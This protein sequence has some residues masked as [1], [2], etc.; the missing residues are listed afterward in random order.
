MGKAKIRERKETQAISAIAERILGLETLE[1]RGSD[2]LDFA[3]QAVWSIEEA[4]RAAYKSGK[5][6][7][8]KA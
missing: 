5:E 4:L 1:A 6:A 3:E 2:R 8:K 7:A